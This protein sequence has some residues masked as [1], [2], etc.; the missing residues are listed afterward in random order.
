MESGLSREF[1]LV[2]YDHGA[3]LVMRLITQEGQDSFK[4]AQCERLLTHSSPTELLGI[5]RTNRALF[6]TRP[7]TTVQ[8]VDQCH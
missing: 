6:R 4:P 8:A 1:E 3:E 5:S 2:G 7:P